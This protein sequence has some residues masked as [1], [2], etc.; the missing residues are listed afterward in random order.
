[1]KRRAASELE[2][3]FVS[4]LRGAL[5]HIVGEP[6][7]DHGD[8]VE[9]HTANGRVLITV[10]GDADKVGVAVR[11]RDNKGASGLDILELLGAPEDA[12]EDWT[13]NPTD[14]DGATSPDQTREG[15]SGPARGPV[16]PKSAPAF[17]ELT[18]GIAADDGRIAKYLTA[19]GLGGDVPAGVGLE[20]Q[21]LKSRRLIVLATNVEGE[22]L[23]LQTLPLDTDGG[24]ALDSSGHKLRRTYAGRKGW[25]ETAAWR[26]PAIEGG[27]TATVIT[28]GFEDALACRI[29]GWQGP[30]A[31]TLGK[32]NAARLDPGTKDIILVFDGDVSSAEVD[33]A[34]EEHSR[35]GRSVCVAAMPVDEDPADLVASG[36]AED[37]LNAL[38]GAQ[39][40]RSIL[41]D[42]ETEIKAFPFTENG[43]VAFAAEISAIARRMGLSG[44][45]G[46]KLVRD[47]RAEMAKADREGNDTEADDADDQ[48]SE[49]A[50]NHVEPWSEPITD[51]AAVLDELLSLFKARVRVPFEPA[52]GAAILWS[53]H[54]RCFRKW[55]TTPR[56]YIHAPAQESGKSKTLDTLTRMT[57]RA[58]KVDYASGPG[59]YREIDRYDSPPV[60][61]VDEVDGHFGKDGVDLKLRTVFNGN[62]TEVESGILLTEEV[63]TGGAKKHVARRIST[64]APIAF[65]GMDALPPTMESRSLVV[66]CQRYKVTSVPGIETVDEASRKLARW[67]DD[68]V[69]NFELDPEMPDFGRDLGPR[70]IDTWRPIVSIARAAGGSW[71][72]LVRQCMSDALSFEPPMNV[73]QRLLLDIR[74]IFD[75]RREDMKLAKSA[76]SAGLDR[77]LVADAIS[78]RSL[79][80][81]LE[82]QEHASDLFGGVSPHETAREQ[83]LARRL[84]EWRIKAIRFRLKGHPDADAEGRV[85]GYRRGDFEDLWSRY[86]I[87]DAVATHA[88]NDE[89]DDPSVCSI[90]YRVLGVNP[91]PPRDG[92]GGDN[93]L[94]QG[95]A[96]K[97][98][99]TYIEIQ[100]TAADRVSGDSSPKPKDTSGRREKP[101]F[102]GGLGSS[103]AA[104]P[105]DNAPSAS[106]DD[107][108]DDL[109]WDEEGNVISLERAA[110]KTDAAADADKAL[111]LKT[112]WAMGHDLRL[113]SNRDFRSYAASLPSELRARLDSVSEL[114][115][116]P[117]EL[118][119]GPRP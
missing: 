12:L 77:S 105:S 62:G 10:S 41:V 48:V 26:L 117:E 32:G 60:I 5:A 57:D 14:V 28:E 37:L 61:M 68:N 79:V 38:K 107:L 31:A 64:L 36:R 59:L 25:T 91:S 1:M 6:D 67:V 65:A 43:D 34:V 45:T 17:R 39:E 15:G 9:Y 109:P 8:E 55:P 97:R 106:L 100:H 13:P 89:D 75:E 83:R 72:D 88:D 115:I 85:R 90:S 7:A 113:N 30:V 20:R 51:G 78:T 111:L 46:Q 16:E 22:P 35:A 29:A 49:A 56:L 98:P 53:A 63:N 66:H 94:S 44:Q 47:K 19:R 18:K 82:E 2:A 112:T 24:C 50:L 40:K 114:G 93:Q 110:P 70:F 23:A 3:T 73:G 84:R 21:K 95:G 103:K 116:D 92:E 69:D 99:E 27:P 54:T 33:K 104:R 108:D 74:R 11:R 119:R 87:D 42:L 58:L 71:P 80:R 118:I 102:S 86:A 52:L 81:E 96:R 4:N 76:K 101:D